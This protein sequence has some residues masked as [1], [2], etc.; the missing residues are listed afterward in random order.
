MSIINDALKKV[1]NNITNKQPGDAKQPERP[2][3]PS[4]Q[5]KSSA[6]PSS[7]AQ[8]QPQPI[9]QNR[10]LSESKPPAS[11]NSTAQPRSFRAPSPIYVIVSGC[12]LIIAA[13]LTMWT[14]FEESRSTTVANS[15]DINI[16]GIMTMGNKKVVLIDQKIYE[17]GDSVRGMTLMEISL[18]EVKFMKD[19][20]IITLQVKP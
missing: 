4:A 13:L 15:Q 9:A 3:E 7:P 6:T 17:I 1:Q 19:G 12:L 8:A 20:D 2:A 10:P 16:Q 11:P 5:S 14:P 18:D